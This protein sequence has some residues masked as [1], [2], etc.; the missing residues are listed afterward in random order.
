MD[1]C[2]K[3]GLIQA[4]RALLAVAE[5][6]AMAGLRDELAAVRWRWRKDRE[7]QPVGLS[8][9]LEDRTHDRLGRQLPPTHRAS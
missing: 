8:S 2:K 4:A 1:F 5:A 7:L 6:G 3:D 9:T